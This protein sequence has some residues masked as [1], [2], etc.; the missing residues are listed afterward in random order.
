LSVLARKEGLGGQESLSIT[1]FTVGQD[2]LP[3]KL[4]VIP[5]KLLS[6]TAERGLLRALGSEKPD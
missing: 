6:G 1:R 2:F 5:V 4:L 3:G